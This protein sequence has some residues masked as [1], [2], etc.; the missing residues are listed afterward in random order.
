[1]LLFFRVRDVP[2]QLHIG[3]ENYV[4]MLEM[5]LQNTSE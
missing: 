3:T 4:E 5:K 1:M 2:F